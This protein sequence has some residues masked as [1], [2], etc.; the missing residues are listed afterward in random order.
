MGGG[1]EGGRDRALRAPGGVLGWRCGWERDGVV[2]RRSEFVVG[3]SDPPHSVRLRLRS[4]PMCVC[5]CVYPMS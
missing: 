1:D 2:V 5:E 4:G 3:R